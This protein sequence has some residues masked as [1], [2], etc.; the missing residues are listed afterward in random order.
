[1]AQYSTEAIILGVKN[2]GEADKLLWFFSRE[3]GKIRAAAYGARRARSLLA[4]VLQPFNKVQVT[5]S[6]GERIDTVRQCSVEIRYKKPA[7]DLTTMAYASFVAE[8]AL[9]LTAEHEQQPEVYE[10][11]GKIFSAFEER[12][13]RL[14]ALA[15]AFRLFAAEGLSLNLDSCI[16]CGQK[17]TEDAFA[18]VK[19]GGALCSACAEKDLPLST[20]ARELIAKLKTINFAEPPAFSVKGADMIAAERLMLAYLP[21]ITEKPLKSLQF[22]GQLN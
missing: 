21:E 14:V 7:E 6:E 1:M 4:G 20:G 18:N 19:E 8:L 10:E 9:E 22:I 2:W 13:P 11:L 15:A 16:H 3:Q 17:I 12:N 5:L